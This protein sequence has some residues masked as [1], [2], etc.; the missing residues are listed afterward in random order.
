MVYNEVIQLSSNQLGSPSWQQRRSALVAML[1]II[2]Y[3]S[4]IYRPSLSTILAQMRPLLFDPVRVV[5]RK[6]AFFFSEIADYCSSVFIE[7][8]PFIQEDIQKVS[9]VTV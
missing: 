2:E 1:V 4:D 9:C 5:R 8:A 7:S 6:A 3:T